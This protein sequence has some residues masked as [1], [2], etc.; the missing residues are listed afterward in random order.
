MEMDITFEG[1]T[2]RTTVYVKMDAFNQLLLSEGVCRQLDMGMYHPSLVSRPILRDRP[3]WS[4]ASQSIRLPPRQSNAVPVHL[5]Y[6]AGGVDQ[7]L[8]ILSL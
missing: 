2:L 5:G 1:K 7:T 6:T 4:Q 3:L 8:I